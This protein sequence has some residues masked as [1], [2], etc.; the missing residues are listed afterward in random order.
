MIGTP[1]DAELNLSKEKLT[2]SLIPAIVLDFRLKTYDKSKVQMMEIIQRS[3]FKVLDV[4][5]GFRPPGISIDQRSG[6]LWIGADVALGYFID[7]KVARGDRRVEM[8][9]ERVI[10]PGEVEVIPSF[11]ADLIMMIAPNPRNIVEDDLLGQMEKFIGPGTKIYLLL[12]N[13]TN[14]SRQFGADARRTIIQFLRK[15]GVVEDDLSDLD[16]RV[17]DTSRSKDAIGGT[18]F[19]G[20]K[21]K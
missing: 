5:P 16:G 12:D 14:E 17:I 3:N 21:I 10:V 18:V 9:A 13:R 7:Q 15:N 6:D 8:G 20:K 1:L 19:K 4:G 2:D 11:Q